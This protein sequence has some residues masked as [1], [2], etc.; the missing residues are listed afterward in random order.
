MTHGTDCCFILFSIAYL[1]FGESRIAFLRVCYFLYSNHLCGAEFI[2]RLADV[3][4][5]IQPN[6]VDVDLVVRECLTLQH[7]NNIDTVIDMVASHN[8][9]ARISNSA[10]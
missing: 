6:A 10:E 8:S 5:V 7:F 2:P 1:N 3:A 9:D 4:H